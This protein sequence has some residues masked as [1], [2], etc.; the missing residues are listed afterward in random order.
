MN[1]FFGPARDGEYVLSDERSSRR[2]RVQGTVFLDHDGDGSFDD[3]DEPLSDVGVQVGG[4]ERR[5]RTG[6]KGRVMMMGLRPRNPVTVQLDQS[7]L[8][9]PYW[10]PKQEG[11]TLV[12]RTGT[13]PEV[14][15]PVIQTGVVDGYVHLQGT[16]KDVPG[17]ELVLLDQEG[18]EVA[19]STT[20]FDGYYV[21]EYIRPGNYILKAKKGERVRIEPTR[22]S[23][24]EDQL[25]KSGLELIATPRTD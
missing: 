14:K 11:Y 25:I 13:V 19:T 21:F 22:V 9:N 15:F 16:E 18:K 7:T 3:S 10:K 2:A 24:S 12:P 6:K 4:G 23:I 5:E 20:A 1:T 17:L 8:R